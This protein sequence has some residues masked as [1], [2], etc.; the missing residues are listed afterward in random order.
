MYIHI[1]SPLLY[2]LFVKIICFIPECSKSKTMLMFR[3]AHNIFLSILSLYMFVIITYETAR[4]G[5][6]SSIES[7]LCSSYN[8][9][10]NVINISNMFLYSKY[11]EWLDTL[12]LHL[13]GKNISMLQYTHHMTTAITVYI[14][15]VDYVSP[16]AMIPMGLNCFVHIPMYWYFAYPKGVLYNFR[17]LITTS[18]I[19][20]HIIVIISI[21]KTMMIENCEQNIYGSKFGLLMYFM[22]LF[23]FAKFYIH[24]YFTKRIKTK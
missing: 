12:F 21:I 18:Q 19:I 8:N 2:S 11:I 20:Q 3:K 6:F 10:K 14:N 7:L 24:S 16:Y 5:K 9:N 4:I 22:Y 15:I 23:Y 1:L 13:S 17:Q